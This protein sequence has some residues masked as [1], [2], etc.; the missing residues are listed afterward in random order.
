MSTVTVTSGPQDEQ[1]R[2]ALA[3]QAA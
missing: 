3:V 2:L 1:E